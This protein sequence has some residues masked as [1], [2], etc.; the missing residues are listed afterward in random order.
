LALVLVFCKSG[1][2]RTQFYR[3][4]TRLGLNGITVRSSLV[5]GPDAAHGLATPAMCVPSHRMCAYKQ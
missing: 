3:I 1:L 2:D 5:F 4:R